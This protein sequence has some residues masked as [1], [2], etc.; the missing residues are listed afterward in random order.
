MSDRETLEDLAT[1]ALKEYADAIRGV[2]K[3]NEKLREIVS[4]Y[5]GPAYAALLEE[6]ERLRAD[7][8]RVAAACNVEMADLRTRWNAAE[9]RIDAALSLAEALQITHP[10]IAVRLRHALKGEK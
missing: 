2:L 8:D 10:Y 4:L 3:E 7:A 9:D 1:W 6:N 5:S